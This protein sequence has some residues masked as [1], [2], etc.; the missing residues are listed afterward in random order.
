MLGSFEIK[1]Y[2]LEI[3]AIQSPKRYESDL[4]NEVQYFLVGQEA[5]KISEVKVGGQ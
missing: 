4:S 5:P 2:S 1:I 3:E